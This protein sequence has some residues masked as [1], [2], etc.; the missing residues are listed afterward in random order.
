[1]ATKAQAQRVADEFCGSIET[2]PDAG[3]AIAYAPEGFVWDGSDASVACVNYGYS[4]DMP[5]VYDDLIE[6]MQ[7]GTLEAP[8]GYDGWWVE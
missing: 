4:G 6:L 7:S 8:D 3:M 1:M 2:D 5:L